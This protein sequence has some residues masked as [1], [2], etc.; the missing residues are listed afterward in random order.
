M[1]TAMAGLHSAR[2]ELALWRAD[3]VLGKSALHGL[4]IR[5]STDTDQA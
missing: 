4:D 3:A 1:G 5:V 2:Q